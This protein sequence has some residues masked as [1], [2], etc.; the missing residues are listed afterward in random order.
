MEAPEDVSVREQLFHD[1]V[2]ETIVSTVYTRRLR[3]NW[4]LACWLECSRCTA[5]IISQLQMQLYL[6]TFTICWICVA[7]G[8]SRDLLLEFVYLY[9]ISQLPF[10]LPLLQYTFSVPPV[11]FVKKN[12]R[13][14]CCYS[15]PKYAPTV[16]YLR[17]LCSSMHFYLSPVYNVT[18]NISQ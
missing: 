7:V 14:C 15:T 6:I 18:T 12:V 16:D 4:E 10:A 8:Y 3:W 13:S 1:R 17:I 11:F 9:H 5:D 2:R